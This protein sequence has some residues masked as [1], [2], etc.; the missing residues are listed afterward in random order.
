M[1]KR[2]ATAPPPRPTC[3]HCGKPMTGERTGEW[4]Q[5]TGWVQ[6][7]KV[8]GAHAVH[9]PVPT[10]KVACEDCMALVRRGIDPANAD[11]QGS[12]L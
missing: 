11:A 1:G 12:L 4:R 3:E 8:G 5:V 10:G 9:G 7:R 6:T 2:K